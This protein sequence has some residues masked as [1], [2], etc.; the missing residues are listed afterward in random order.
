MCDKD[1]TKESSLVRLDS[2]VDAG[3]TVHLF[4]DS[5]MA[6]VITWGEDREQARQDMVQALNGYHIEGVHTS[7]GS[8]TAATLSK[9]PSAAWSG[10]SKSTTPGS[11][12]WTLSCPR[13][14]PRPRRTS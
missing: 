12:A 13:R 10:S 6:K 9:P 14:R 3:S 4:Y 8:T 2:G 11:G 1:E 7:S 5:I